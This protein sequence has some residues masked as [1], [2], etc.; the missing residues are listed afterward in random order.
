MKA[1]MFRHAFWVS[2]VDPSSLFETYQ[3][4][5]IQSGFKILSFTDFYFQPQGYTVL[6]LLAESHLA[7]HTFP[8]DGK[9]Y[10]ELSSCI[11]DKYLN[12]LQNL[13]ED[14]LI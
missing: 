9:S 2:D 6:F 7:I 5:L 13:G 11:L 10:V 8:E 1:Q 14:I 3:N 12:F 4:L